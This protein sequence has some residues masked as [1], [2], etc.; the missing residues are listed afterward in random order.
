MKKTILAIAIPALFASAANAAVIYE[1]DG[2]TLAL[3]G[4][5]KVQFQSDIAKGDG[6][7][8]Y[9]NVKDGDFGFALGYDLGQNYTVGGKVS[10]E[11]DNDNDITRKDMYLGVMGDFGAFTFGRQTLITDSIGI[12]RD[13]E[14]GYKGFI[15]NL[16]LRADQVVKYEL[17]TGMF[18]GG[19]SHMLNADESAEV[20]YYDPATSTWVGL[21]N[22]VDPKNSASLTDGRLG[23]RAGGFDGRVYYAQ[24]ETLASAKSNLWAIEADYS[25]SDFTISASINEFKD[26]DSG[27]KNKLFALTGEY[28]MDAWSFAAGWGQA[29]QDIGYTSTNKV[30]DYYVN[31]QYDFSSNVNAFAELGFS[32]ADNT[33]TGYVVGMSAS[34]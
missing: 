16:D 11:L 17:D 25:F 5:A 22:A 14:F 15:D 19:I 12:G 34:F 9:I 4:A 10:Y 8:N 26:K 24:A 32:D 29:K 18:Y 21:G 3:E 28:V 13:K 30:N 7:S 2:V 31:A 27:D 23:F 33:R 1:Q 20:E 6:N